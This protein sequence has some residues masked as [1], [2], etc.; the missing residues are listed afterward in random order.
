[1]EIEAFEIMT[2]N[3]TFNSD[4]M[5]QLLNN[6]IDGSRTV[7]QRAFDTHRV[8]FWSPIVL[9]VDDQDTAPTTPE[10]I[11]IFYKLVMEALRA[12]PGERPFKT[13]TNSAV[14][15]LAY[16]RH[17]IWKAKFILPRL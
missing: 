1:M 16:I 13:Y 15:S 5:I 8:S 12:L 4:E 3:P 11:Q 7:A 10:N 14:E 2:S 9:K 17:D 6:N